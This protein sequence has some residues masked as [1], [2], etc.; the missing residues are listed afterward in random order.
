M[1]SVCT[2][3]RP[4]TTS[5]PLILAVTVMV[6]TS[7]R[8]VPSTR[9]WFLPVRNSAVPR[10]MTSLGVTTLESAK[11]VLPAVFPTVTRIVYCWPLVSPPTVAVSKDLALTG[12]TTP[13]GRRPGRPGRRSG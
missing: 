2:P 10:V 9:H 4:S 8:D 11:A 13:T 7:A 3:T 12:V 5:V 1:P 6:P